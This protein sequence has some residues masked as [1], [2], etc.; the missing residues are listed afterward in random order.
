MQQRFLLR[1]LKQFPLIVFLHIGPNAKRKKAKRKQKQK[2]TPHGFLEISLFQSTRMGLE[3]E[4]TGISPSLSVSPLS[5]ARPL[6]GGTR[7][8]TLSSALE[9]GAGPNMRRVWLS[10]LPSPFHFRNLLS[11]RFPDVSQFIFLERGNREI[12]S[13][14]KRGCQ[15]EISLRHTY[16]FCLVWFSK[17]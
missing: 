2:K 8:A 3:S 15:W 17:E 7:Q 6:R 11:E 9:K 13:N 4:R 10:S 5:A 14:S 1:P 12:C 16:Q